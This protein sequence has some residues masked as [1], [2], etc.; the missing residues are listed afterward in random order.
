[1][2]GRKRIGKILVRFCT[3]FRYDAGYF[4]HSLEK[5]GVLATFAIRLQNRQI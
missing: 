4:R 5:M 1:M 3:L 2:C